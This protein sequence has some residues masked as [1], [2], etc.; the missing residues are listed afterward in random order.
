[1]ILQHS[2]TNVLRTHE[3]AKRAIALDSAHAGAM[4]RQALATPSYREVI[5]HA[6]LEAVVRLNDAGMTRAIEAALTSDQLP[7]EALG[8]LAG[9]GHKAALDALVRHLSDR[10]AGVR[11]YIV[12]GW[13]FA[14]MMPDHATVL[15]RLKEA[16]PHIRYADTRKSVQALIEHPPEPGMMRRR[17]G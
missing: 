6:A 1:M 7:A 17:G 8:V 16:E 15:A 13:R 3:M 10:R 12:G 4:I 11:R 9:R 14:L 5:R 2:R